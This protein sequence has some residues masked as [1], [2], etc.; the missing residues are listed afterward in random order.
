MTL[1]NQLQLLNTEFDSLKQKI[2]TKLQLKD[3]TITETTQ[4]LNDLQGKL[5]GLQSKHDESNR[6]LELTAKENDE[7]EKVLEQLLKEMKELAK[8][9]V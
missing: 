6:K 9:L 1:K 5:S 8:E 3:K 7:N 4:K 2:T